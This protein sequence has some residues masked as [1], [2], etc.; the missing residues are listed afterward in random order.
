MS[1]STDFQGKEYKQAV[2][3]VLDGQRDSNYEYGVAT[4]TGVHVY[5]L[6]TGVRISHNEFGG[7]A[8]GGFSAFCQTGNEPHCVLNGGDWSRNGVIDDA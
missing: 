7:R 5:V 3:E 4:G 2:G 6:D 1:C 8:R